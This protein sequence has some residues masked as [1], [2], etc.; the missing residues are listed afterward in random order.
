VRALW[1]VW[2]GKFDFVL[3]TWQFVCFPV[4]T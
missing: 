4:M 3:E 2:F 1:L